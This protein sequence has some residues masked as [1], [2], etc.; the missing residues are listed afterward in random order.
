MSEI[1]HG[2]SG[3]SIGGLICKILAG[4]DV[5]CDLEEKSTSS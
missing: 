3:S 5:T 2:S 1:L 4:S